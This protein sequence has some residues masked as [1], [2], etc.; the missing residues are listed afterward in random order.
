MAMGPLG[1]PPAGSLPGKPSLPGNMAGGPAGPGASPALAPGD[2]AGNAAA[3]DALVKAIIPALHKAL[4]AYPIGSKQYKGVMRAL[5]S[6]TAEFGQENK[7]SMVPAAIMQMAQAAKG[8][9]PMA[10][11][12]PPGIAPAGGPGPAGGPSPEANPMAA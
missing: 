8:G 10:A 7:G 3:A 6:L 11:A 5:S 4:S 12:P 2:G 9:S 1:M